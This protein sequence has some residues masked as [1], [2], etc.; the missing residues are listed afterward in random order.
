MKKTAMFLTACLLAGSC[1][2][3][4]AEESEAAVSL[5]DL[6]QHIIP[7]LHLCRE[8]IFHAGDRLFL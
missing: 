6:V 1:M 5:F 8:N 7:D 4:H 2:A 3:V